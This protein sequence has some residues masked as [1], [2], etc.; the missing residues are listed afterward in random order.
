MKKQNN[1]PAPPQAPSADG[2]LTIR[3][4]NEFAYPLSV[5]P[6]GSGESVL[7]NFNAPNP[8][9]PNDVA[10]KVQF[11][12]V[13]SATRFFFGADEGASTDPD[14]DFWFEVIT[15]R[16]RTNSI[17]PITLTNILAEGEGMLFEPGLRLLRWYKKNPD[18]PLLERLTSVRI[19]ASTA[20]PAPPR[21][22]EAP[23]D[24]Q[25]H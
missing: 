19:T 6:A 10:V 16:K 8:P 5:P 12:N 23:V 21:T 18:S 14:Q 20:A 7:Y 4:K 15:T 1:T 2:T 25:K 17:D 24:T 3:D 11:I 13:P 22:S 9:V